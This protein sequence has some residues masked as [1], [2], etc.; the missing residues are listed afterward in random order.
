MIKG[1]R[2]DLVP[3]WGWESPGPGR[4]LVAGAGLAGLGVARSLARRGWEV[5]V[6]D[7]CWGRDEPRPHGGHAAAALTPVASRDD[8]ARARL[9]RAG[10][11]CARSAWQDLPEAVVTRCGAIQLQRLSGRV[12]DLAGI[13]RTPGLPAQWIR[14]VDATQASEIAGVALDRPGLHFPMALRVRVQPLLDALAA[15]QGVRI[16]KGAVHS[17]RPLHGEW[18]ALDAEGQ[19]LAQAQQAVLACGVGVREILQASG[20]LQA[21]SR[22][23]AM[24][25]LAGEITMIPAHGALG[26]LRCTLGGDGYVLPAVDGWCVTGG[27]Y[28]HGATQAQVT[29]KGQAEHLARAAGLLGPSW[30]PG[31]L[32]GDAALPGWAGWRAVLP[33]RL[34]AIGPVTGSPGLWVA[35]GY[36]SRGLTWSSLAGELIGASLAG[37]PLPLERDLL[38]EI[39]PN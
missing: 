36:A 1:A 20:L 2:I 11:L 3:A 18:A 9:S 21:K 30:G 4:V 29:A 25:A 19:V 33:G 14:Y 26:Q 10:V 32:A 15:T 37:E 12:V 28:V 16:V 8:N 13:D 38:A 34:P 27:T 31:E 23:H 6:L 35:T 22:V 5:T 24:H 17:L 39:N 7:P